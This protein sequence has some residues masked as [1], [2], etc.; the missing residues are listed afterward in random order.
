MKLSKS[1]RVWN[2]IYP[3]AIYFV[4][5]AVTLFALDFVLPE[6]VDSK[7]LRQ[8]I[9]SVAAIP[10]LYSFY[11][12]DQIMRGKAEA[13]IPLLKQWKNALSPDKLKLCVAMFFTGGCLA[14]AWNNILGM[15][16]IADYSS[17]YSKVTQ[18]FYTGRIVLEIT[19]LCVIIPMV[20][21]LLYRGI[22]YGRLRDWLGV[23][24]ALVVS[25]IIFGAVH[26][27]LVQFIYASVFGLLLAYIAEVNKSL[28]CAISA[29]MAA[30]LT[31]VLRAE[32]K[33]FDFMNHSLMIQIIVTILLLVIAGVWVKNNP[34][35]EK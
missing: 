6:T 33:L 11:R 21:E 7:L 34:K 1:M 14:V 4:V 17:A 10:F 24:A 32:T 20:E 35:R 27:N 3:I 9:T 16:H 12:S 13:G 23:P 30:N 28:W 25:A 19:A 18:T 5:T 2:V 8:F 31:S 15:V 26:M 29:H 22:V